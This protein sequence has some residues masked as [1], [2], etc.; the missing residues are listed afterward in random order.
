MSEFVG[1]ES[2]FL[3]GYAAAVKDIRKE[4]CEIVRL[5]K[6]FDLRTVDKAV[7]DLTK[8]LGKEYQDGEGQCE[9]VQK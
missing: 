1:H 3:Q 4:L 7:K 8:N 6:P 5:K 2:V 9:V